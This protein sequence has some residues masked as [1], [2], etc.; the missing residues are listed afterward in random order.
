MLG[1]AHPRRVGLQQGLDHP[2]IQ[3]AP[4]PPALTPVKPRSPP[5]TPAT[6]APG[7]LTWA[8]MR[9]Q[10]LGLGVEL[11]LLHHGALHT[12]QPMP[13]LSRKHAVLLTCGFLPSQA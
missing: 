2:Q 1:A 10:H 11:D 3:S 13:Y 4:P 9:H 6:P 5:A 8:H 7:P 12:Q